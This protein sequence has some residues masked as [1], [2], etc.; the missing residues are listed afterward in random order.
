MPVKELSDALDFTVLK[1]VNQVGV[2]INNASAS[3]LKYVSGLKKIY[4]RKYL[5][6]IKKWLVR[7]THREEIKKNKRN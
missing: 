2:N 6:I 7:L 4:H 3:I 5:I 1:V